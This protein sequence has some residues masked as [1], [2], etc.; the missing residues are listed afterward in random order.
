MAT[1]QEKPKY[2]Q[3]LKIRTPVGICKWFQLYESKETD[4]GPKYNLTLELTPAIAANFEKQINDFLNKAAVEAKKV[5]PKTIVVPYDLPLSK[6]GIPTLYLSK[7]AVFKDGSPAPTP[8]VVDAN[9]QP[10]VDKIAVG[11]GSKIVASVEVST[12]LKDGVFKVSKPKLRAAQIIELV[13]YS[14]G[15]GSKVNAADEFEATEGYTFTA[16]PVQ[17]TTDDGDQSF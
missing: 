4:Y 17:E 6:E 12:R 16:T 15:G 8:P 11:T 14:G 9:L 5:K 1:K 7:D 13:P 3:T 2:E 10:I